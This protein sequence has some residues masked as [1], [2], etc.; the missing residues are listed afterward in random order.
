MKLTAHI[1]KALLLALVMACS[2]TMAR[3]AGDAPPRIKVSGEG[4]A[5]LAPNMAIVTLTVNRE[6]ETARAALDE[7]TKAMAA[8][9]SALDEEGIAPKDVQTSNFSIQPRYVYPKPRSEHPP[10]IV[11]YTVRNGL[12]VRVRDIARLGELL[13]RS[14]TLGVNEGGD[15]RFTHDDPAAALS[16]ART[17]AV[18]A[19]LTKARTIAAAAGVKMGEILAISEYAR[20]PQPRPLMMEAAAMARSADAAPVPVAAGENSYKVVV[21]MVVAIDQ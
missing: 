17:A 7:N 20:E 21:E 18:K 1:L 10:R 15:V 19:A 16:E 14:V 13:D 6:G 3:A 12:T 9:L 11:G 4:V 5:T 2:V 8:V